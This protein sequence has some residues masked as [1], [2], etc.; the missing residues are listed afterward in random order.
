MCARRAFFFLKSPARCCETG[1][2]TAKMS[3]PSS[4]IY[5]KN[6]HDHSM[7]LVAAKQRE[8]LTNRA[9]RRGK[10]SLLVLDWCVVP[11]RHQSKSQQG[12]LHMEDAAVEVMTFHSISHRKVMV[13]A[14]SCDWLEIPR[15]Y[16]RD[17]PKNLI[18]LI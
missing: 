5:T 2:G 15:S 6:G 4:Q 18:T 1:S 14:T 9:R 3:A 16:R 11:K 13:G 12:T 17:G 7:R 8:V 10:S